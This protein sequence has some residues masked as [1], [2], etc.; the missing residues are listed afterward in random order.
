MVFAGLLLLAAQAYAAPP[1]FYTDPKAASDA[2]R[3]D[4]KLIFAYFTMDG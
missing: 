2:A 1:G 4:G 3:Q